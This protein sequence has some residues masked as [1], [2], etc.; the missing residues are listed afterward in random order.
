MDNKI[1]NEKIIYDI[2]YW[3]KHNL[4]NIKY[5]WANKEYNIIC[6]S[7][8]NFIK[9]SDNIPP[10]ENIREIGCNCI[11][12][13]NLMRLN[14]GK[15]L[16]GYNN[17]DVIKCKFVGTISLWIFCLNDN[18]KVFDINNSYPIGTL[19]I[20]RTNKYSYGHIA[21]ICGHN[22]ILHSYPENPTYSPGLL[23]PGICIDNLI[24]IK[25]KW[26]FENTLF[27]FS[28]HPDIWLFKDF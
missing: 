2:I 23:E 21:I 11:G 17:E 20:K 9:S 3:A 25:N 18:L 12:L 13:I 15:N 26:N 1:I 22:M 19:L 8:Y 6:D 4:L 5:R 10:L 14:L 28:C 24:D 16:P 7:M 27:D